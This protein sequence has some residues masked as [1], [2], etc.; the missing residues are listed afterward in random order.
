[1]S[2]DG[3]D[4]REA[5]EA[6]ISSPGLPRARAD[7]EIV[8]A[9]TD[10]FLVT[11]PALAG[12]QSMGVEER[13]LIHKMD[14]RHSP[15]EILATFTRQFGWS[16][17]PRQLRDFTEQLR[18]L[19]MLAGLHGRD[20]PPVAQDRPAPEWANRLCDLGVLLFGWLLHPLWVVPVLGLAAVACLG[21]LA[22]L[23]E[24]FADLWGIL[25]PL[26]LP[27]FMGK[28]LLALVSISFLR[29]AALGVACRSLK[30][31]VR[32]FGLKWHRS[33]LPHF[34]CIPVLPIGRLGQSGQRLLCWV[35]LWTHLALAS[36]A[37]IGWLMAP[38]G[39]SLGS[40]CLLASLPLV[41]GFALQCIPFAPLDVYRILSARY[42][43]HRLYERAG[44]ETRAWLTLSPSPE[45]LSDRE[46]TWFRLFGLGVGA[47]RILS[48]A[49]LMGGG[50]WYVSVRFGGPGAGLALT[51]VIL[52][53]LGTLRRVLSASFV[54]RWLASAAR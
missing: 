20:V 3:A 42:G 30:G 23:D 53:Y 6:E 16:L 48:L 17:P 32:S 50:S 36:L 13:F 12:S 39:S 33:V 21:V 15:D 7:L 51:V 29:S 45:A 52:W 14:G 11:T 31:T 22:R 9:G 34:V 38:R 2:G 18:S 24:W 44:A 47:Y 10:R 46:R 37:L 54:G 25:G 43:F 19:G 49:V 8:R 5:P 28:L 27:Q 40:L 1:V 4:D 26:S 41:V 35:R